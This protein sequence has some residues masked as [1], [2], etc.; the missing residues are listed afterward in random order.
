MSLCTLK[1][2][3]VAYKSFSLRTRLQP[4]E[5]GKYWGVPSKLTVFIAWNSQT[6]IPFFAQNE[7][8][9]FVHISYIETVLE[10][11]SLRLAL[12]LHFSNVYPPF[13]GHFLD[14]ILVE[15]K[16]NA[17]ASLLSNMFPGALLFITL[18]GRDPK[19]SCCNVTQV[20]V[21]HGGK[22]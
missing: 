21:N 5:S 3:L 13:N 8:F 20:W 17:G 15:K 18:L 12:S 14:L 4:S 11:I 6:W 19:D 2:V 1:V 9:G 7:D 10:D 22:D 16:G